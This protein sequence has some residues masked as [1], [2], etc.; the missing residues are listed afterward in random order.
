MAAENLSTYNFVSFNVNVLYITVYVRP[1]F[2]FF[3][4]LFLPNDLGLVVSLATSPDC[5]V[6]LLCFAPT[7]AGQLLFL[8]VKLG[9]STLF[10]PADSR[11]I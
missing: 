5:V 3:F 11:R 6:Q 10:S 8:L 1:A 7:H 4:L 9:L 2:F